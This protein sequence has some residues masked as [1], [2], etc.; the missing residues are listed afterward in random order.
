MPIAIRISITFL[1]KFFG[2]K[3]PLQEVTALKLC[4]K[5]AFLY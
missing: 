1:L 2:T 4:F 3:K 5:I